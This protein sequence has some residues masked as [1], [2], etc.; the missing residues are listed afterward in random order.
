MISPLWFSIFLG[1]LLSLIFIPFW[2]KKARAI[3][4]VW[5]DM[6]K[7]GNPN[8]VAASGGIVVVIAFIIAVFSYVALNTFI[9]DNFTY[10]L[11]IFSLIGVVLIL[12][13][14]GLTDDLLGWN[15]GGLSARIRVVLALISSIPLIVI[16]AGTN[17]MNLPFFGAINFG[18][19][20]PLIIIPLAIAF[21]TT[22]YNFLAGFNGLEAGQGVLVL[23]FLS[24]VSYVTGNGWLSVIGLCMVASLIG[25]YVYN[26]YPAKVF[27]GDVLTYSIGALIAGMAILGNFEKIAFVVFIPYIIEAV[28][29][30]GRGKLKKHSFGIPD[31]N[32]NLKLPY[33]KI[34]G[35]THFSIF[36][37]SK[38]KKGVREKDVSRFIF[39]IQIIFILIALAMI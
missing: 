10:T 18:W 23:T 24:Y 34:Y 11:E 12:A 37:L 20:Y 13:L 8:N 33:E 6:N 36:F 2:I 29:K 15:N 25:F 4:L 39:A 9:F 16:N 22:T 7:Y 32:G 1:F 28:L 21:V 31:K 5:K 26:R 19:V 38:F 35:L 3:N 14:V 27:P 30:A 17:T